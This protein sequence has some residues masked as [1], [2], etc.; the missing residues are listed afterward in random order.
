[1]P[2]I[3]DLR[4]DELLR[5][6]GYDLIDEHHPGIRISIYEEPN[7]SHQYVIGADFALG[8]VGRDK[9]AFCVLD[10]TGGRK[11]Q[12]AEV[13]ATLGE[14]ADKVLFGLSEYYGGCFIL[15]ERQVGLP[16]LRRLL[17]EFGYGWLYY[18]RDESKKHRPVTDKLGYFKRGNWT[19]DPALRA[20]RIAIRQKDIEIR[21]EQ[22]IDQLS[23]LQFKA[24]TTIDPEEA[25]DAD[26][27]VKL[28]GG[29]QGASKS[30]DLVIALAYAYHACGEVDNFPVPRPQF[31][32]GSMGAILGHD[33]DFPQ[34]ERSTYAPGT[35]PRKRARSLG[36]LKDL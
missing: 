13:E 4:P 3:T 17:N 36:N 34:P 5:A 35:P 10:N 31:A 30:P 26:M 27:Q 23:R 21:S 18:E 22:L 28:S 12:V 24:K 32:A 2:P 20:L 8:M 7:P 16:S 29:K 6:I 25:L 14:V 33:E 1:M 19:S 9:D 15:G 11:V